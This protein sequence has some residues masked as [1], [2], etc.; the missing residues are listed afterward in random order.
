M[1]LL[2][3]IAV[4]LSLISGTMIATDRAFADGD[5]INFAT[6]GG[7][8][9][10]KAQTIYSLRLTPTTKP[11]QTFAFHGYRGEVALLI[12]YKT[13]GPEGF[14]SFYATAATLENGFHEADGGYET[15]NTRGGGVGLT[16]PMPIKGPVALLTYASLGAETAKFRQTGATPKDQMYKICPHGRLGFGLGPVAHGRGI[17]LRLD[18]TA[19]YYLLGDEAGEESST[20]VINLTGFD[21]SPSFGYMATF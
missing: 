14:L 21:G 18:L 7:G 4:C 11:D 1:S 10:L 6:G 9:E 2:F 19:Y 20:K 16:L 12:P 5:I 15:L 13:K 8:L 3:R 17:F